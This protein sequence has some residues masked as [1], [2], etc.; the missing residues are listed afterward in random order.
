MRFLTPALF[1]AAAL[2]VRHANATDANRVLVLPLIEVFFPSTTGEP[3]AQGQATVTALFVLA[4][5]FAV[6]DGIA[7]LRS[8]NADGA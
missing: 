6:W 4:A 2:Y 8:R 1:L 7:W 3:V 5:I